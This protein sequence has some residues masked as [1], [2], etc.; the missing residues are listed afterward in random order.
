MYTVNVELLH[1]S[2][3]DERN[4]DIRIKIGVASTKVKTREN[5][6]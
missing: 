4:E 5:R 6:L 1:L 2:R 3:E